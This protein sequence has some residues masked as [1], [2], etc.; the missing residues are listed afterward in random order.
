M[1]ITLIGKY[2]NRIVSSA[3]RRMKHKTGSNCLVITTKNKG[4]QTVEVTEETMM[5]LLKRF[6]NEL[7]AEYGSHDGSVAA[8]Y[9]YKNAIIIDKLGEHLTD[10]GKLLIDVL[11]KQASEY[12]CEQLSKED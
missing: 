3:L 12:I 8:E 4:L 5:A 7:R 10:T 9:A 1:N 6:E 2:K 11:L